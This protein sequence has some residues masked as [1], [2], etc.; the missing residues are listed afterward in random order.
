MRGRQDGRTERVRQGRR[1]GEGMGLEARTLRET[2][3]EGRRNGT[4]NLEGRRWRKE[5][6]EKRKREVRKGWESGFIILHI[7]LLLRCLPCLSMVILPSPSTPLY[8]GTVPMPRRVTLMVQCS[9]AG[10]YVS[11]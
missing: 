1:E 9:A 4:G 3:P 5:R 11:V 8:S 6:G 10:A 2:G 7:T